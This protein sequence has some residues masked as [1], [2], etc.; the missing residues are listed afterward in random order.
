MMN[1]HEPT[2]QDAV[3]DT[4][5]Y[6]SSIAVVSGIY[7]AGAGAVAMGS[8]PMGIG[9]SGWIMLTVGG[10]V[11]VH[12]IVLLTP[13]ARRIAR[14]SG[15]L[16]VLWAA[17]ML[18]NQALAATVPSWTMGRP[19]TGAGSMG[20]DAGMVAIA[21]LMLISGLIMSRRRSRPPS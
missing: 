15:P 18:A 10:V 20:W 14:L 9:V 11:L 16:M 6:A 8:M 17:I 4:R 5:L 3:V 12:G 21:I 13:A 2:A 19:M 7:S 1:L